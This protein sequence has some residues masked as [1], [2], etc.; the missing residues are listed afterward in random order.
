MPAVVD[1]LK[2]RL[3][4]AR[5]R[6][7]LLDQLIRTV[8]HYGDV[9][10]NLQAGAVTYFA[11]I[12]FFPVVALAFAVIGYLAKIYP[13]ANEDLVKA[14]N[15]LLPGLVGEGENQVS[16][17]SIRDAAPGILSVGI[18]VVLYSGLGW[19]SSMRDSLLVMFEM[20]EW[21]HPN[22]V[23]GKLRDLLALALLGA[24]L[25]VAVGVSGVAR[26]SSE[27]ILEWLGLADGLGWLLGLVA[28]LVGV[29][30]NTV[31][32]FSL[33]KVLVEPDLP[34][35]ALLS[36]ALLGAI[37]FEVLKQVSQLLLASTK[38]APA[39]Q[40]FGIALILVVWINYFSRVVMYAAAWAF[41]HPASRA[42]RPEAAAPVQGPKSPPAYRRVAGPAREPGARSWAAPF[43]A[44]GAATVAALA[45][46]RKLD[47]RDR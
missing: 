1:R 13:D 14:I 12:S 36:G 34:T 3:A 35:R 17:D 37:G 25:L 31:L 7:P 22:F 19:L 15:S 18:L 28:V 33:F 45:L 5:E 27:Q 23:V 16:I 41:V 29:V 40:A 4:D 42:L 44:G 9:K 24:V 47:R 21:T 26:G 10:G 30:A 39:F 11:F 6:R 38:N 20:P 8:E 46:I 2:E 43:A 32:F